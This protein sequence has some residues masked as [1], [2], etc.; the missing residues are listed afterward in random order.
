MA[1]NAREFT[2]IQLSYLRS[3]AFIRGY[4]GEFLCQ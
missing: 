2:Q 1:A 4:F 3:F